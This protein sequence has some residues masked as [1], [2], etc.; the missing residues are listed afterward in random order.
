MRSTLFLRS[1]LR[2][3][4]VRGVARRKGVLVNVTQAALLA[5]VV[6]GCD[7]RARVTEPNGAPSVSRDAASEASGAATQ[8]DPAFLVLAKA[9]RDSAAA[10]VKH[11]RLSSETQRAVYAYCSLI[12]AEVD[13]LLASVRALRAAPNPPKTGPAASYVEEARM[14]SEWIELMRRSSTRG[15]LARYQDLATAWNAWQPNDAIDVDP[16]K[17]PEYL[18]IEAGTKSSRL[19]WTQC[20]TVPCVLTGRAPLVEGEE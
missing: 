14:F 7:T 17:V 6:A 19:V 15:T 18:S 2:E 1:A 20:G 4:R 9:V 5:V 13:A 8:V 16:A 11:C 3:G 10:V 12:P